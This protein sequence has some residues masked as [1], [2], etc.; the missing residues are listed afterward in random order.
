MW[1][2]KPHWFKLP[3][4]IRRRIWDTY[5]PGQEVRKDPDDPYLDAAREARDW[6]REQ[7]RK[8]RLFREGKTP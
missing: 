5:V 2:C 8:E 3:A 4:A 7:N 6:V 1:G